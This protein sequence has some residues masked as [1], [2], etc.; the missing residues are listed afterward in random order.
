M[1]LSSW[2]PVIA[3]LI[4]EKFF[5][6]SQIKIYVSFFRVSKGVK[7]SVIAKWDQKEIITI[8][9]HNFYI[10]IKHST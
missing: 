5:Y 6:C 1:N 7:V 9:I 3:V 4:K 10:D 2:L 8:H